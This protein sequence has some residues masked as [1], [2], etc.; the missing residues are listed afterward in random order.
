LKKSLEI[1]FFVKD[2]GP[3]V[4]H[5]H[6]E[7]IFDKYFQLEKKGDGRIYTTGLGLTF[8]K[9]AVKT[10]KGNIGVESERLD[11]SRFFFVLPLKKAGAC[12]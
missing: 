11:G 8:C 3:G 12:S 10:H 2:K 9:M 6:Q 1:E 5:E 4:P 7:P